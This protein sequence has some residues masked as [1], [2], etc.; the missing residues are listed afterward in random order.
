MPSRNVSAEVEGLAAERERLRQ[1][2]A[3]GASGLLVVHALTDAVDTAV[4]GIWDRV[5]SDRRAALVAV[6]GYGRRHM[7]PAS[8]VDLMVLHHRGDDV[9]GPAQAL[10]YELWDAGLDVGHSIRTPRE[11]IK[12]AKGNFDAE[13]A[14]LDSRLIAGD[15]ALFEEFRETALAYSRRS[16]EAFVRRVRTAVAARLLKAG[17]A[18]SELE[19]NIKDGRGG[20]RDVHTLRWIELVTGR[21]HGPDLHDAVDLLLRVRNELH[22]M[23]GRH[24]D[25]LFMHHQSQVASALLGAGAEDELMRV[26]YERCRSIAYALDDALGETLTPPALEEA[27]TPQARRAFLSVLAQGEEGRAAFRGLEQNGTLV[28]SLPEW[29]SIRCLPQ[30]N[31]Y[32]RYPVDVHAF[33]TVVALVSLRSAPDDLVRD[34]A[35]ETAPDWEV[36]LLAA[37]LHDIGK[38]TQE[39]HSIRGEGLARAAATRI[40]L[41]P[42]AAEEVA[43]LVRHHLLMSDTATRRDIS[44][45]ALVVET[46]ESVGSIRRLRMLYLLSV[47]DGMATGPAAW[48][49]WKASLVS[50]L[51]ARV[52][53][54]LQAGDLVSRDAS[55]LA[56]MRLAELREALRRF[57]ASAVAAQLANMPR[58]WLLSQSVGALTRQAALMLGAEDAE[59]TIV[60][61]TSSGE[62]GVSEV[63]VIA[64]DRP[65]LFSRVSG[66]LALH[67]LNVLAAHVFT[68]GDGVALEVF[69]VED[70]GD[71]GRRLAGV[72]EDLDRVLRGEI[73]L[74]EVLAAKRAEYALRLP[75]GKREPSRVMVDNRVSDFYSVIEVHAAD[76]IGLLYSVTRTLA[77]LGLNIHLAKVATYGEDVVDTFYVRDVEGQKL[78]DDRRAR[79]IER[80]ILAAI[81]PEG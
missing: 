64:R 45:E 44:D 60:H 12:V 43:W 5:G 79:E 63:T 42:E 14:F 49:P 27:W 80:K 30:R 52:G 67:G 75:K 36:A 71:G 68:R 41:T 13:T 48:S 47:A 7:N 34:V 32:H 38:G 59:R 66:V 50:E 74:D 29:E 51:F 58:A 24:A 62:P 33:E 4:R 69:R 3:A 20:L 16:P 22:F 55:E 65:G 21:G 57:P 78:E 9:A 11:A 61:H 53:H 39:D 17:D 8:D 73:G 37:L 25:V 81:A 72:R 6:G 35:E 19:P 56:K 28:R 23:T 2:H 77:L 54:V 10:F 18:S 70:K 76:R 40:G 1:E 26:L 31:V 15:A 46:A